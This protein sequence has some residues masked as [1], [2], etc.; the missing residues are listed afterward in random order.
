MIQFLRIEGV[1]F[2]AFLDDTLDLSIIRGGSLLLLRAS[3]LARQVIE[4]NGMRVTVV[5]SGASVGIFSFE[6]SA[7]QSDAIRQRIENTLVADQ[8]L[9]HA[10]FVVDTAPQGADF[11]QTRAQLMAKNRWR[12]MQTLSLVYP[13]SE[14]TLID[15]QRVCEADHLRPAAQELRHWDTLER[16]ERIEA[17]SHSSFQR[18]EYGR[19]QRV[20]FYEEEAGLRDGIFAD[21]L[22]E[23]AGDAKDYGPLDRKV[24]VIHLDGNKF[25]TL[26]AG[27]CQTP[28]LQ[29]NASSKL[30][31]YQ[32]SFLTVL[33]QAIHDYGKGWYFRRFL[34][35]GQAKDAFRLETLIWGGD[36]LRFVVPAWKAFY[37][38]DLF[39]HAARSWQLFGN[40]IPVTHSAGLVF[41][42]CKCNIHSAA[43]LAKE[44]C[45]T[46]KEIYRED[47]GNDAD[48]LVY[49]VL[50]SFDHIGQGV[51]R[52]YMTERFPFLGAN[53]LPMTIRAASLHA[54]WM[55]AAI[56]RDRVPRRRL[57][58]VVRHLMAK[59]LDLA[60]QVMEDTCG[61]LADSLPRLRRFS[62]LLGGADEFNP[63]AWFH[64]NEL[65]DYAGFETWQFPVRAA[66]N[67]Q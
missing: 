67:N 28:E 55:E 16:K 6:A 38:L 52:N 27:H 58:D 32:K 3:E 53:A 2:R 42:N 65:W 13:L 19:E 31:G 4:E 66:G 26:F 22:N 18:H 30:R 60:N 39:F 64:L 9:R 57:H 56:L 51:N 17:L 36:E 8:Q 47:H 35:N 25:G 34:E 43:A 33:F 21:D 62:S 5:N 48:L 37:F 44:L 46:A 1:N 40:G 15:G 14:P 45:E 11:A 41:C 24:A 12:Q 29:A 20:R 63:A 50:E 49:Q 54:L 59:R 61:E 7:E 23:I 10:T